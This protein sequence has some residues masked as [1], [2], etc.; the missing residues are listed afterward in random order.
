MLVGVIGTAVN[1]IM[2]VLLLNVLEMGTE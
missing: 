1:I 2:H